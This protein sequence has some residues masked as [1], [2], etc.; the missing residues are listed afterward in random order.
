MFE[1]Y[2][3]YTKGDGWEI[4]DFEGWVPGKAIG[5]RDVQLSLQLPA[6]HHCIHE[7]VVRDD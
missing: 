4:R 3:V 2:R 1:G 6:G 7:V 5:H